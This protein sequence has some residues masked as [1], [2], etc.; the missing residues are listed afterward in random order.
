MRI[1]G[2]LLLC[3]DLGQEWSCCHPQTF[4]SCVHTAG[5][6]TRLNQHHA[7]GKPG[8]C[9][10]SRWGALKRVGVSWCQMEGEVE[11][12]LDPGLPFATLLSVP[13]LP[14]VASEFAG[15]TVK[16]GKTGSMDRGPHV[17]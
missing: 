3:L 13:P 16:T 2:V 14:A 9:R 10:G 11:R 12:R 7:Q 6:A 15:S 4:L 1:R 8:C 5:G 17:C